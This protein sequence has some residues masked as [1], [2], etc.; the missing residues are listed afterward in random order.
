MPS[1][2]PAAKLFWVNHWNF[3]DFRHRNPFDGSLLLLY[4]IP[5]KNGK[6][7]MSTVWRLS[8]GDAADT[9]GL[10]GGKNPSYLLSPSYCS[11]PHS[12]PLMSRQ[13]NPQVDCA[14]TSARP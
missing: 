3:T 1:T 10:S 5:G 12:A 13:D 11:L 6:G 2:L 4:V 7:Q 8:E 9:L 14:P